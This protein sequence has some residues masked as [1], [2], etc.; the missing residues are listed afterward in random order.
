MSGEWAR[1]SALQAV[2][3][4]IADL[5]GDVEA[6]FA[7]AGIS[8]SVLQQPDLPLPAQAV[9]ELLDRKSVV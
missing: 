7:D 9:V 5:G 6:A 1:S 4:L 8:V 3:Q 2:D